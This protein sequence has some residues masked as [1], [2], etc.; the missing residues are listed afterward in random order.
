MKR[1]LKEQIRENNL[2]LKTLIRTQVN[3]FLLDLGNKNIPSITSVDI[4][5]LYLETT[6]YYLNLCD[7]NITLSKDSKEFLQLFEALLLNRI[8]EL[9]IEE[10]NPYANVVIQDPYAF[11]HND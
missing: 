9:K 3:K 7:E 2:M 6:Q 1:E 11:N 10:K 5:K 4:L 8:K